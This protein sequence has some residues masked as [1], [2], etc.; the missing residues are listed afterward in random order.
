[1][2]LVI[3]GLARYSDYVSTGWNLNVYQTRRS[4]LKALMHFP[5]Q[6]GITS[7]GTMIYWVPLY[8]SAGLDTKLSN[9]HVFV[10]GLALSRILKNDRKVGMRPNARQIV[11]LITDGEFQY[12]L[13]MQSQ[14]LRNE[15]VELYVIGK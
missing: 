11:V 10:T 3:S 6:G 5:N 1:M 15:G 13:Y 9:M 14:R 4:L 2:I 12:E 8:L 7:T